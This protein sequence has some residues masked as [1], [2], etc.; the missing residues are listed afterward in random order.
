[1]GIENRDY[2]RDERSSYSWEDRPQGRGWSAVKW[3]IVITV[4]VFV[5]QLLLG[6]EFTERLLL[7]TGAVRQGAVWQLLTYAFLHSTTNI[8]H[9]VFNMWIFHMAGRDLEA[10]RGSA[11]L[12]AFYVVSSLFAGIVILL[13]SLVT[14]KPTATLGASGAVSAVLM[15]FAFTHP[16]AEVRLF[17]VLPMRMLT[18]A[19]GVI[20]IDS[21]PLL[22]EL[23]GRVDPRDRVSHSGHVGGILLG[24]LYQRNGWRVLSWFPGSG[25]F[26]S[27]RRSFR[28]QPS[29]RVHRPAEAE[30]DFG[31]DFDRRVDALLDKVAQQGEGSLTVDERNL[32]MEASRRARNRLSK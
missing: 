27:L 12:V 4:G 14:G 15:E 16:R 13:W 5:L 7:D 1:M 22:M 20:V 31:P 25:A 26:T 2:Y 6:P 30:P 21:L 11:E 10:R 23:A 32:L 19:I 17:G 18:F 8:W 29:L 9:I 24:I 28:K 3:I